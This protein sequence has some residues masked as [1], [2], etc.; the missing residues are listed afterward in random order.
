M[1]QLRAQQTSIWTYT[2]MME[3]VIRDLFKV[4]V[5]SIFSL[6]NNVFYLNTTAIMDNLLILIIS[7]PGP[8]SIDINNELTE[9][10]Y[11][12]TS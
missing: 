11:L 3:I 6:Y 8:K 5:I 10:K 2:S 12:C 4:S 1:A 7:I 9:I